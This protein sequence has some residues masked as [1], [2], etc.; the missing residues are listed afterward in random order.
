MSV[1]YAPKGLFGILTPQANT[2]VEPETA[3]LLPPGFAA[4]TGRLTSAAPTMDA[5]LREYFQSYGA[6]LEQFANAP[7][8]AVGFACTGASY[9]AGPQAEDAAL[10]AISARAGVPAITAATA[11]CDA[12]AAL[13]ARRIALVSPYGPALDTASLAYW[14]AR[15]L[16][17]TAVSA[18]RE[19]TASFHPIYAV[20]SEAA[21]AALD[22][23]DAPGAQAVAML[24]TGL[25]T[26]RAIRRCE[27]RAG[28][29]VIS[30]VFCLI[31]R[32][33]AVA[34]GCAPDGADLRR[35]LAGARWAP[36]LDA[37]PTA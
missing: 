9:L 7:L 31:W 21:S 19:A 29:P 18:V 11:V 27:G 26:L 12:L 22:A 16:E 25:P 8:T 15:G 36:R 24:G 32:L 13:G 17:V 23:L 34:E 2:T 37:L 20:S 30:S 3:L 1:D 6:T 35:W 33:V 14:T 28:A 5:R 10:A 4:L